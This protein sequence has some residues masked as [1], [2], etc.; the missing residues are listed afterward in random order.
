MFLGIHKLIM[1]V[2]SCKVTRLINFLQRNLTNCFKELKEIIYKQ[3]VLPVFEYTATVWDPYH[4]HNINKIE[5]IQHRAVYFAFA[6]PWIRDI[7][8]SITSCYHHLDGLLY[9]LD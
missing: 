3:L 8:D 7:K 1:Y 5:M 4:H 6:C 2:C 9:S